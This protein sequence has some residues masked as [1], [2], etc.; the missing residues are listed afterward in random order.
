MPVVVRPA[1]PADHP[2]IAELTAGVYVGEGFSGADYE[3]ALRDV[4]GRAGSASVLVAVDGERIVGAVTVA[5]RGGEW[6]EQAA[7]GEA[8]IR[9]LVV[10]A[11]QRGAGVGAALVVRCLEQARDDGCTVVRLSTQTDMRAA[12][13]L[14]ARLG[15]E[16][17]PA[18]DW[19][20]VPGLTLLGYAIDLSTEGGSAAVRPPGRGDA[21]R[22]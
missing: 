4:A 10:A 5:T 21:A 15:F 11:D 16:R 9:M 17:T 2:A 7:S 22:P 14:Y 8:V 1:D 20:P 3:P 13:R 19:Q 18:Y 6:A 12:H